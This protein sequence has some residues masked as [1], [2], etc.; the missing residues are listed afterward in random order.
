[1]TLNNVCL[2]MNKSSAESK[3]YWINQGGQSTE[4]AGVAPIGGMGLTEIIFRHHEE[5]RHLKKIITIKETTTILELGCGNGRWIQSLAPFVS[6]YVG[7]DFSSTMLDLAQTRVTQADLVNVT[8]IQAEAQDFE[9]DG[10]FDLIYLSGISQY[11][12]DDELLA[13]IIRLVQHLKPGG[14][15][16][17]RS[18]TH[19][20]ER[21]MSQQPG[22]FCIYRTRA[23]IVALYTLAGIA[24]TYQGPSYIFLNF[25]S[26]FYKK[27]NHRWCHKLIINANPVFISL[28]RVSA[29]LSSAI[30]GELGEVRDY[31]HDFLRFHRAS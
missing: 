30:F 17:D 26:M 11:I 27:L 13:I 21:T 3:M 1:M 10:K 24:N 19:R 22:Y 5:V 31:S 15:I 6:R 18:T 7:V 2:V 9:P 25:P 28:L 23:E 16:L 20:R 4:L 29:R 8:L 14:A 12:D